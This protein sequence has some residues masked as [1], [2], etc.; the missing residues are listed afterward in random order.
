MTMAEL[1]SALE[2]KGRPMDKGDY[3][4]VKGPD[5]MSHILIC[6]NVDVSYNTRDG[7]ED[8]SYTFM[9]VCDVFKQGI[10]TSEIEVVK[11]INCFTC[12][13]KQL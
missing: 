12:N 5:G 6:T 9:C 13:L 8:R 11:T 10:R 1:L 2:V 4:F 7:G 3:E